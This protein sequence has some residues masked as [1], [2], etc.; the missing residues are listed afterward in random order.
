MVNADL[1]TAPGM[2]SLH[3]IR[4]GEDVPADVGLQGI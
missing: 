1:Y 2:P 4:L 3:Q